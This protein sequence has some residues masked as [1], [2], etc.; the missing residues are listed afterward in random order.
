MIRTV[1]RRILL[2]AIAVLYSAK[3]DA[4]VLTLEVQ[5]PTLETSL[6]NN[7]AAAIST[8]AYRILSAAGALNA[9]TWQSIA[10]SAASDPVAVTAALG[11]G[12]LSF[13]EIGISNNELA[14][15]NF[16]SSGT[17]QPGTRWS[18]GFPFGTMPGFPLDA[19]FEYIDA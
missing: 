4:Q 8:D 19:T 12:A 10:D 17:W 7:S 14:E 18:I 2:G 6:A 9:A 13:V 5:L 11:S 15:F 16:V 3:A 1:S